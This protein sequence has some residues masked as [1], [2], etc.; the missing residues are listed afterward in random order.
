MD[1]NLN[2]YR[3]MPVQYYVAR[4]GFPFIA[5]SF[6][7]TVFF[8]AFGFSILVLLFASITLFIVFFFRNPDR[9]TPQDEDAVVSPADGTV[10]AIEEGVNSAYR[11]GASTKVSIFMSVFNVH[12]NRAPIT[13]LVR[14][15]NYHAGSFFVASLD[16]ASEQ[17]E[18]NAILFEDEKGRLVGI[19]QIAGLIA[20]RIVCYLKPT[21]KVVKGG[22]L[23]LIRFGSRVDVYL[24]PEVKVLVSKGEK[25]KSGETIVGRF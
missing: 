20:R 7:V 8:Y 19:V 12:I 6:L 16:K 23:G 9:T 22:R 10:I 2:A 15:V 21:D 25:V 11:P 1:K 18:R 5:I 14:N 17:N 4:E 3:S 13:G 24:P